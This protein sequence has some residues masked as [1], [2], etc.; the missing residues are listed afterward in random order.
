MTEAINKKVMAWLNTN[1]ENKIFVAL[2][3]VFALDRVANYFFHVPFFVTASL[4][5]IPIIIYFTKDS[6][7]GFNL[8]SVILIAFILISVTNVLIYKF[9]RNN[10]SDPAFI[11]LFILSYYLYKSKISEL[12]PKY[13]HLLFLVSFLLFAFTFFGIDAGKALIET[14]ERDF[15]PFRDSLLVT[16]PKPLEVI[17]FRREY[18][19]GLF[20]L[21]HIASYFFGFLALFYTYLYSKT[22]NIL[23]LLFGALVAFFHF[24][25]GSRTLLAG[26]LL[27][28][29]LFTFRRKYLVYSAVLIT[30]ILCVVL[31][32]DAILNYTQGTF[33]YQYFSFI[34][35]FV[36]N[37]SGLSRVKIWSSWLHEIKQF[38][39][40][41]FVIGNSFVN[42]II[43][44][45]RNLG[46]P[47]W[48]DNDYLS[49]FYSYGTICALLYMAFWVK[50]FID[51]KKQIIGNMFI[52]IFYFTMFFAAIF[53]GF[54]YY[55]PVFLLYLFFLMIKSEKQAEVAS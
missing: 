30:G 2:L 40:I 39:F 33:V 28:L 36:D 7:K 29:F 52:F 9:H 4:V 55:F 42:S 10:I 16:K 25:C 46:C 26:V 32:I 44:N 15:K 49:I 12:S 27:S 48:F 31:N 11:L 5:F 43:A 41:E 24:Y 21:A 19:Q 34:K 17:E 14:Q 50:I 13:A 20:R 53:N 35:S 51:F 22:K 1:A 23:Y 18:H 3:A 6:L 45:T 47:T 38:G 37:I 8:Y 54:Y